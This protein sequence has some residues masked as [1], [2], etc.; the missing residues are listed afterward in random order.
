[1]WRSGL[2]AHQTQDSLFSLPR[3]GELRTQKL[4]SHLMRTQSL[5]VLPLKPGI[6]QYITMHATFTARDFFLANFYPSGPF[7]CIFPKPLLSFS[8][9]GCGW[10]G[11]LCGLQN[12]IGHPAH[13]Y[14]ELIQ[15]PL[16]SVLGIKIDA[17]TCAIVFLGLHFKIV[18]I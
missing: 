10:N 5:K 11:F 8:C 12:K 2:M 18:D 14:G 17:K 13:R 4:N 16:L 9:V 3:S 15:V 1:M 6:G 7:I